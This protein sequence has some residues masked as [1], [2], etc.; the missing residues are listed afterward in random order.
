[1]IR[2]STATAV[3]FALIAA[4]T[5]AAGCDALRPYD[6]ASNA[7][8]WSQP[9]PHVSAPKPG[10][11]DAKPWP[12]D[13]FTA[14]PIYKNVKTFNGGRIIS[15]LGPLF[16]FEAREDGT[17]RMY[18]PGVLTHGTKKDN[19][20][21]HT[22]AAGRMLWPLFSWKST[23]NETTFVLYPLLWIKN[24]VLPQGDGRPDRENLDIKIAGG[25]INFNVDSEEGVSGGILPL[26]GTFRHLFARDKI[27]FFAPLICKT[28]GEG[29]T[30][31]HYPW[32][33]IGHWSNSD[34]SRSGKRIFP[35][36][37]VDENRGKWH[38]RAILWPFWN[39]YHSQ[40]DTRNP[41][42][43]W[44]FFPFYT[45]RVSPRR[46]QHSILLIFNYYKRLVPKETGR[47]LRSQTDGADESPDAEL[48]TQ[49]QYKSYSLWPVF[50][51]DIGED[52]FALAVWPL[53]KYRNAPHIKHITI[54]PGRETFLPIG[55]ALNFLRGKGSS[56][57]L[58]MQSGA[59]TL[60]PATALIFENE[61]TTYRDYVQSV[62]RWALFAYHRTRRWFELNIDDE[63]F[64]RARPPLGVFQKPAPLSSKRFSVLRS[65][66]FSDSLSASLVWT[67]KTDTRSLVWPF[68]RYDRDASGA[69]RLNALSPIF[70]PDPA[71]TVDAHY[72]FL[73]ELFRYEAPANGDRRFRAL[74]GTVRA[75]WADGYLHH[76]LYPVYDWWR[77][78][79]CPDR[80][81]FTLADG[82]LYRDYRSPMAIETGNILFRYRNESE[83]SVVTAGG[84]DQN[85][86]SRR[87]RRWEILWGLLG[88]EKT[89]NERNGKSFHPETHV[90]FLW[91]TF[92]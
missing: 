50:N 22:D 24:R 42:H 18:I 26:F 63:T 31:W 59:E 47:S 65:E 57:L 10:I 58:E 82:I 13:G 49:V 62:N 25:I 80:R 85:A 35:F 12:W 30:G 92:D 74:F 44:S 5:F 86:T 72:G 81:L 71:G 8:D 69:M 29:V 41:M 76:E 17:E 33:L 55:L 54:G 52:R 53:F 70:F 3:R 1:M 40:L 91:I 2:R 90:R 46:E 88:I 14:G 67:P 66:G 60:I 51:F 39:E 75:D 23:S 83:P 84:P 32:P 48:S 79:D 21:G 56:E 20:S 89:Q 43:S 78:S 34:G 64:R 38:K 77:A 45:K 6:P 87:V 37:T 4:L 68:W 73:W 11:D 36:Y 7:P 28:E 19:V 61:Q 15:A 9:T 16:R 27:T